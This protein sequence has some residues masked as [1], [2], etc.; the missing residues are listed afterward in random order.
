MKTIKGYKGFD[1]GLKCRGFQYKVGKTYETDGEPVLCENG[2][3]FCTEPLDVFGYY[4]PGGSVFHSV[5]GMDKS[6]AATDD[7]KIAVS[8]IKIGAE[9]SLFDF[10][11]IG[12]DCILKRC[13]KNTE[14]N[15]GY[16]SAAMNSGN[17]SA[18]MN[19]GD[20]S[21]AMNSGYRSAAMNSGY[22]S[23]A[24]NSGDSSAAMNSGDSSAAM[25]S[26]NSSAAVNSGDSSAAEVNGDHSIAC[27]FGYDNKAKASLGSW[28]ILTEW[29]SEGIYYIK[30]LKSIKVDGKRIKADTFYKL[31]D[32]KFI[33][34]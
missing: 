24:M 16:S 26:G 29:G 4:S 23:A 6:K 18:A 28:I 2:F 22:S 19:S 1:K 32:G 27:G 8:K 17:S 31:E 10:I 21:A 20:R 15:S 33:K 9:I 3:H 12:V 25:N 13:K 30:N 14:K 11:K 34:S 5:D 7:S